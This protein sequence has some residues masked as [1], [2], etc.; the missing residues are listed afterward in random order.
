MSQYIVHTKQDIKSMLSVCKVKNIDDLFLTIPKNLRLK[1]LN[2]AKG[3]SQLEVMRIMS[4][5]AA[6]NKQFNTILRGAGAYNHYIPPVVNHLSSRSE[7]VTAYTPYQA[8]MSQGVLQSIYEY[9]TMIANLT[10]MDV[11]NASVYDGASAAAEAVVMSIEKNRK[12]LVVSCNINPMTL[13]VLRTHL[14]P[15]GMEIIVTNS[16]GKTK[17]KEIAKYVTDDTAA[18]YIEQPNY[19]GIIED[20]EEI[21]KIVK[22][23]KANYIMGVNPISLAILKNPGECHADIAVGEGQPL[24]MPLSFGGPYLGFI[25][26]KDKLTRK[27]CGR[28]V[29]ETVDS[30]G[31]RAFVLTLQ[32]REQHIRREKALSNICSNQ[33]LCALRAAIYLAANGPEGLREVATQCVSKAHYAKDKFVATGLMSE[34]YNDEFFHEFV[35]KTNVPADKILNALAKRNILGGLKLSGDA[36][37]WC[38]TEMVTKSQIDK[39]ARIIKEAAL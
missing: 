15:L 30:E 25:A 7:F 36:I 10:G 5:Y 23:T 34:I 21:G 28:I 12:K 29:G 39:A 18:I 33:A 20:A 19:Y 37:L 6:Q 8:E 32:A 11:S 9:Q 26:A 13:E 14:E 3:K 27:M 16:K 1:R 24:G 31:K 35:M 22:D 38:V 2:L 4:A 17:I